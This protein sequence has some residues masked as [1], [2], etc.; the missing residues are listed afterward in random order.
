MKPLSDYYHHPGMDDGHLGNCKDCRRK[1]Q[2]EKAERLK[3]DPDFRAARS[4]YTRKRKLRDTYGIT[5]EEYD[6]LAAKYGGKCAICGT[7]E[8]GHKSPFFP[9][10]H[11]HETGAVRGLLCH[12]CNLGI[13]HFADDP[14]RLVAAAAYLLAT[15]DVLE[16]A[17]F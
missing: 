11:D 14:D 4:R 15:R 5:P 10:D 8:P 6:A 3:D 9:V 1:Y 16:G 13:G 17:S 12:D 7:T 2:R